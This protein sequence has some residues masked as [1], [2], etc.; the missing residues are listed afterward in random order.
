MGDYQL[1]KGS[2]VWIPVSGYRWAE[3]QIV[4]VDQSETDG[5]PSGAVT[6][7]VFTAQRGKKKLHGR[8]R[9]RELMPRD[10]SLEGRDRPSLWVK[11]S[12]LPD[13][14]YKR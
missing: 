13:K 11:P 1:V 3:G 6:Y 4:F 14:K 7:V 9:L 8:R 12:E 2:R 5:S 10:L